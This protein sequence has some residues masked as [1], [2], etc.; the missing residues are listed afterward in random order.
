[1]NVICVFIYA[2]DVC[3]RFHL[4]GYIEFSICDFVKFFLG[5]LGCVRSAQQNTRGSVASARSV[6]L[7][8]QSISGENMPGGNT[9]RIHRLKEP[10]SY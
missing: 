8:L 2:V 6:H 1:M 10:H 9:R 4:R 3:V 5:S 7:N